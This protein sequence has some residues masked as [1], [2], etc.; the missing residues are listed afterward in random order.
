MTEES[1]YTIFGMDGLFTA[2]SVALA[3]QLLSKC[4][5]PIWSKKTQTL[6]LLSVMISSHSS[7]YSQ[8]Q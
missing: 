6:F 1:I 5:L 4:D 8:L 2:G 7:C 3:Y